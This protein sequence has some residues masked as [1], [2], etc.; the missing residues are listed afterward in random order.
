M[1][2]V[3]SK[4]NDLVSPLYHIIRSENGRFIEPAD[5]RGVLPL[6]PHKLNQS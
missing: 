1:G 2:V 4:R 5:L 3:I 6:S